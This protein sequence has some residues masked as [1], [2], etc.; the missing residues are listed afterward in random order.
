MFCEN[1]FLNNSFINFF[2]IAIYLQPDKTFLEFFKV[3]QQNKAFRNPHT[4]G[5]S[6]KFYKL[7]LL[8]SMKCYA[9]GP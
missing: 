6:R 7:K 5:I 1:M 8:S 3:A 2:E 9:K 4:E